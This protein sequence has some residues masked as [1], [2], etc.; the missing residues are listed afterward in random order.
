[1]SAQEL[2]DLIS[3]MNPYENVQFTLE[4]MSYYNTHKILPT[5]TILIELASSIVYPPNSQK[6]EEVY[7]GPGLQIMYPESV[8]ESSIPESI[9]KSV[10]EKALEEI[11]KVIPKIE[12]P[13]EPEKVIMTKDKWEVRINAITKTLKP[14]ILQEFE[15]N[16]KEMEE[17]LGHE[18][19]AQEQCRLIDN[20][21]KKKQKQLKVF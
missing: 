5:L 9:E 12:Q 19:S 7:P 3:L 11:A 4:Y 21:L 14:E 20:I 8:V 17:I 16:K 15:D 13:K 2:N 10:G 6:K 1:M 18:L